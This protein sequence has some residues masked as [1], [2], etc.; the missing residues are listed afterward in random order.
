MHYETY[1]YLLTID[2]MYYL[3]DSIFFPQ[4]LNVDPDQSR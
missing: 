4:N 2:T 3:L 1:E